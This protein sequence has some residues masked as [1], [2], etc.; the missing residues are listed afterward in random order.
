MSELLYSVKIKIN[1]SNFDL[2]KNF[3]TSI[4]PLNYLYSL[5]DTMSFTNKDLYLKY[6]NEL[7]MNIRRIMIGCIGKDVKI[8]M[9]EDCNNNFLR[10]KGL[11]MF[12]KSQSFQDSIK[13]IES[14]YL[15]KIEIENPDEYIDIFNLFFDEHGTRGKLYN[16]FKFLYKFS[17]EVIE[18][19][20]VRTEVSI[21]N[22]EFS[23]SWHTLSSAQ[24]NIYIVDSNT[25]KR[26]LNISNYPNELKNYLRYERRCL[27]F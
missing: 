22:L 10:F 14:T 2:V 18:V 15:K 21:L 8:S 4:G 26:K 20:S 11:M 6:M 5:A 3:F 12:L 25:P 13:K 16:E 1:R 9:L 23:F 19:F 24:Y 17:D 27:L 7:C